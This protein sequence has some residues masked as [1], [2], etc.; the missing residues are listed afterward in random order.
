M[1][2]ELYLTPDEFEPNAL[3]GKI[4]VAIDVL[5]ASTTIITALQNGCRRI[6][7]VAEVETA[8]KLAQI[9][10]QETTL[11]GGEREGKKLEG[12]HL[13][14]SP[15]E[16]TP[17]SVIHKTL[18]FTTTNGTRLLNKTQEAELTLIAAFV[19]GTQI[20]EYLYQTGKNFAILCAG[21]EGHFSLEDTVCAGMIFSNLY[22]I[23]SNKLQINDLVL[24]AMILYQ[25]FE[26]NI[27]SMLKLAQHGRYLIQIGFEND[28]INCSNV[29]AIP[30]IP[31]FYNG[32]V[33]L[34]QSEI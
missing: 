4:A 5:R 6:L 30:I 13:G 29:D 12:F 19:N 15:R 7:P 2:A 8:R 31:V 27:L 21:T 16:Y 26:N 3:Q 20:A 17:A 18:I 23:A 11:L 22:K 24:S 9:Q 14:N 34:L 25:K 10:S 33:E 28:L 32:V 1:K